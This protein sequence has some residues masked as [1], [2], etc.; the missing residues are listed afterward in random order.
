MASGAGGRAGSTA[1]ARAGFLEQS[2]IPLF[3]E[4]LS[5]ALVSANGARSVA[6]NRRG[7]VESGHSLQ[8]A[9]DSSLVT[10]E[11]ANKTVGVLLLQRQRSFG[12]WSEDTGCESGSKAG[13]ETFVG[14]GEVNQAGEV[15]HAG[16]E[17]GDIGEA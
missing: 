12:L 2:P 10:E 17:G 5:I 3:H 9:E 4:G 14:R 1:T 15:V 16:V 11:I 13:Y 7:V 6:S 8:L